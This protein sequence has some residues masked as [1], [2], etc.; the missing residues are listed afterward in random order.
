MPKIKM[1]EKMSAYKV[2]YLADRPGE[3]GVKAINDTGASK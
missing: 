2:T 3:I 1:I